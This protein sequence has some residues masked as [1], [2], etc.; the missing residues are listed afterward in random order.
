VLADVAPDPGGGFVA[1]GS[2]T[3][4]ADSAV[5]TPLAWASP[6]GRRWARQPVPAVPQDAELQAVTADGHDLVAAGVLGHGFGLWR[7]AE[8]SQQWRPAGRFGGTAGSGLPYVTGLVRG[9]GALYATVRDGSRYRLWF[10][11]ERGTGG[12]SELALP[13]AVRGTGA[14]A[15]ELAAV[16]DRMLLATEDGTVSRLWLAGPG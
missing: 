7:R 15:V 12:W 8:G 6:D 14:T 13:V 11:A 4:A 1:V 5:R 16:G 2:L 10:G 3:S 9:G